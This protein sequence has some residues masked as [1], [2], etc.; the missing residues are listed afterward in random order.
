MAGPH[1]WIAIYSDPEGMPRAWASGSDKTK[2]I[3]TADK[4]LALYR[5]AKA[6]LGDPLAY[7]K[8]TLKVEW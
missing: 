1:A 2:V 5:K 7:A 6:K 4:N 8:F 3:A